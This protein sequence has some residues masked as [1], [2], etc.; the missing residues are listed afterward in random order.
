L[1][2]GTLEG[3][4]GTVFQL[5]NNLSPLIETIPTGGKVGKRVLILGNGLTGA[6]SVTFNGMPA[7]FKVQKDSFITATVP[8]GAT[9]GTVSVVTR[10]G[11]LNSNPQ[12]VVTK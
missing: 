10:S 11:T 12:F 3:S 9:T 8:A 2:Y 1:L 7:E 4:N 5:S 6:T